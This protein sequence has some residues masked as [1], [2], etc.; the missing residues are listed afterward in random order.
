MDK[1]KILIVEDEGIQAM[2]LEETLVSLGYEVAGV[3]DNGREALEI[4]REGDVDLVILDVHIKG[5]MDGIETAKRMLEVDRI[6]IVYLTAFM[7]N[8]TQQRADETNPAAYLTK[9]YRDSALQSAIEAALVT[10][11]EGG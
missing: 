1:V 4:I 2:A 7:D 3:V 5:S 11:G 9:P 8:F 6:A 10:S